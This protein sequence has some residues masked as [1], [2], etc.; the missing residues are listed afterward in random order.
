MKRHL[1]RIAIAIMVII[2]LGLAITIALIVKAETKT[3]PG[4]TVSG[5]PILKSSKV[6]EQGGELLFVR[7][8]VC[9]PEGVTTVK[10][11]AQG[12]PFTYKDVELVNSF[13]LGQFTIDAAAPVCF[14]PSETLILLPTNIVPGNYVIRLETLV[15]TPN[16]PVITTSYSP[17]FRVVKAE[18]PFTPDELKVAR[19]AIEDFYATQE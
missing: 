11:W 8:S 5:S 10:R 16:G 4:V 13:D 2:L 12:A 17:H 3:Y 15:D 18:P 1:S 6:V 19:Q 14:A 9:V 7:D